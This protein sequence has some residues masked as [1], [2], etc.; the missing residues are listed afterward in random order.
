MADLRKLIIMCTRPEHVLYAVRG[1]EYYHFKKMDFAEDINNSFIK[2]CVTHKAPEAALPLLLWKKCRIGAWT[3]PSSLTRLLT[4]LKEKNMLSELVD[5]TLSLEPR[6]VL[7][8]EQHLEMLFEACIEQGDAAAYD[9]VVE[10]GAKRV[11][12]A[13][14]SALKARFP[15][16][17]GAAPAE[18]EGAK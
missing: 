16:P 15:R 17:A 7:I 12:D 18:A 4:S 8:Q 10:M 6:G 13:V 2:C 3:T 9:K 5:V 11:D 14:M 1:V